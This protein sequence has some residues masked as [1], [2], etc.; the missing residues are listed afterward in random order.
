MASKTGQVIYLK[1][2]D[3]GQKGDRGP[4]LRGPMDWEKMATG[5][6]FQCGAAG[7]DFLDVVIYGGKYYQCI[8][9]HKKTASNYPGSNYNYWRV[10]SNLSFV[11]TDLLLAT[12]ALIKNLGV[13]SVEMKD[14]EG[15]VIFRAKDGNV[16]CKTGTF[17]NVTV[18]GTLKGVSGS[19]KALTCVDDD[20][21]S[22]CQITFSPEGRMWFNNGD[23]YHQGT[24]DGRSLRL[25]GSDIWCRGYFAARQR[26]IARV[27]GRTV[28]Y[29][30]K[31][32]TSAAQTKILT[33]KPASDGQ[34]YYSVPC[35]GDTGDMSGMPV[36]TIVFSN[37]STDYRYEL[38]M[39]ETQRVL[40]INGQDDGASHT[41]LYLNGTLYT[42]NGGESM[43][44]VKLPPAWMV[45]TPAE[46]AVGR[47]IALVSRYDDNW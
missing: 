17:E 5:F 27:V 34:T 9:S 21:N 39:V 1:K 15:N 13:E 2:G 28:Y 12:Y 10:S 11:A 43:T 32:V 26:I 18:S 14:A 31:G 37:A 33:A 24:K 38:G 20:G 29:Y 8:V 46:G 7:E 3:P 47:G 22:V 6:Q 45:N 19:F 42:L 44:L 23:L 25:Y 35:Y 30:P 40:V 4:S 16:T 41:L 36:D